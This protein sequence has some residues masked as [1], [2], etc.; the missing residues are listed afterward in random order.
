M[1]AVELGGRVEYSFM[2]VAVKIVRAQDAK[3]TLGSL[4][5]YKQSAKD[6]FFCIDI[7]RQISLAQLNHLC[8][9]KGF[10]RQ[11]RMV[12]RAVK[13]G[14]LRALFQSTNT[15]KGDSVLRPAIIGAAF[16]SFNILFRN[17]AL[18]F[19]LG[20]VVLAAID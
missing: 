2:A 4:A 7:M 17:I 5:I 18:I 15:K 12:R 3:N 9:R 1:S 10:Y 19:T 14:G 16:F 8:A 11:A 20:F 6:T 13:P